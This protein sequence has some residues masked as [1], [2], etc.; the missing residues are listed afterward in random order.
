[1]RGLT[2]QVG[3]ILVR[4]GGR[5]SQMS[6]TTKQHIG[7]K[8]SE[9]AVGGPAFVEARLMDDRG[10]HQWM[11]KD[12]L[13]QWVHYQKAHR[14]GSLAVANRIPGAVSRRGAGCAAIQRRA[15]QVGARICVE[16]FG[17]TAEY[18][19]ETF[20]QRRGLGAEVELCDAVRKFSQRQRIAGRRRQDRCLR[21]R[22]QRHTRLV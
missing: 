4:S 14:D 18:L 1:M 7:V 3:D 21:R 13:P 22:R 5:S 8:P 11:A 2:Q 12:A 6:G 17:A 15:Q 16:S 19:N 10:A 9:V 20:G